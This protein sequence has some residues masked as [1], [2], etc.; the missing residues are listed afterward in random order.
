MINWPSSF[1][2]NIPG[3]GS[4]G[5]AWHGP[6]RR[7]TP[8][9]PFFARTTCSRRRAAPRAP[10][11]VSTILIVIFGEILPQ[12]ACSRYA[13]QVG[14]RTV[15][16]VRCL[17]CCFYIFTKPMSIVLDWL[18]GH[19]MGTVLS[20]SPRVRHFGSDQFREC[21]GTIQGYIDRGGAAP[22]A[23]PLAQPPPMA[24][25]RLSPQSVGNCCSA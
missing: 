8:A 15:P 12:A 9:V 14:A 21:Q 5:V 10:A 18:L 22:R 17:L 4:S 25:A 3:R 13:L 20:R 16:I 2:A 24:R 1:I 19:E 23:P 11:E 6:P 7:A